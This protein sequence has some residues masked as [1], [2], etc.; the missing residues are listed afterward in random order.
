MRQHLG[1]TVGGGLFRSACINPSVNAYSVAT[2]LCKGGYYTFATE[3]I[4]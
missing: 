1:E 4:K 3:E 2:F